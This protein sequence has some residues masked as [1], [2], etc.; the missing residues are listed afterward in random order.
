LSG[1]ALKA[2]HAKLTEG[3]GNGILSDSGGVLGQQHFTQPP[4]RYTEATLV[5]RMEELG[6]GRPSTYAS[7]LDTVQ[8]RGYVTKDKGRLFPEDKGRL[9]TAFLV[10]YF[11]RYPRI[12][13]HRHAGGRA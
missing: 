11:R 7:I 5:K 4:P 2:D 3:G 12:R 8:A 10:N 13:L 6:I 1:D 9:V